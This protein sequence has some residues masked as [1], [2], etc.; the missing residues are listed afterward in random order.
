MAHEPEPATVNPP[1]VPGDELP[2]GQQAL[3]HIGHDEHG[4]PATASPLPAT[5]GSVLNRWTTGAWSTAV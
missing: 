1:L 3:Q 4:G 2:A 5:A